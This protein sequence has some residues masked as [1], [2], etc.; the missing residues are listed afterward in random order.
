MERNAFK[1]TVVHPSGLM[2]GLVGT[3]NGKVKGGISGQYERIARDNYD[4]ISVSKSI[5]SAS[6]DSEKLKNFGGVL[7]LDDFTIE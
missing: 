6:T 7:V 5:N 3:D 1:W 4:N 2:I